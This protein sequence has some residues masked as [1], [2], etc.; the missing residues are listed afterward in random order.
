MNLL[1]PG[2]RA[3]LDRADLF[4]RM[5]RLFDEAFAVV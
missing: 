5:A 1:D 4:R 2:I 3:G